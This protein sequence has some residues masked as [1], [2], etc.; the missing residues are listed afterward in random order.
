MS[1][2]QKRRYRGMN[3]GREA[4]GS[5][6]VSASKRRKVFTIVEGHEEASVVQPGVRD[7]QTLEGVHNRTTVSV[8]V[9]RHLHY[10]SDHYSVHQKVLMRIPFPGETPDTPQEE[11]YTPV[12]WEFFTY[13][14]RLKASPFL[15]SLL[16]SIG[17]APVQLLLF[18]ADKALTPSHGNYKAIVSGRSLIQKVSGSKDSPVATPIPKP[19]PDIHTKGPKVFLD[20]TSER[21]ET[22]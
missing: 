8:V 7:S 14:V 16:S 21:H 5:S 2:S 9:K 20:T 13:G 4:G 1:N 15:N 22:P 17:R 11:G 18:K 19:L 6:K 12:F 3:I 10:L